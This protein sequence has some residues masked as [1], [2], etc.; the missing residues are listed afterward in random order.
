MLHRILFLGLL[1]S[2]LAAAQPARTQNDAVQLFNNIHVLPGAPVND[3]V[4]FLC[5]VRADGPV[6]GDIVVFFGNLRIDG[7]TA[8]SDVVDF[9]GNVQVED[10]STVGGDLVHIVG[11]TSLGN[12][13]YVG[14]DFTALFSDVRST[15][16]TRV[17][18]DRMVIPEWLLLLPLFVAILVVV[19]IAY[20]VQLRRRPR[21]LYP[22]Q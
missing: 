2:T 9:F 20:L 13:V 14:G 1:A 11:P 22:P 12:N 19:L 5:D 21:L 3:A 10:N 18:G 16:S 7:Q 15:L 4:C 17:V 6:N 8:N